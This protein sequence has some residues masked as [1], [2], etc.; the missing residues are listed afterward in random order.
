MVNSVSNTEILSN[1]VPTESEIPFSKK[2]I[3]VC[4][5]SAKKINCSFCPI[6]SYT[7][8]TIIRKDNKIINQDIKLR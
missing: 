3:S 8:R 5:E 6:I 4:S 1:N 7:I 2:E